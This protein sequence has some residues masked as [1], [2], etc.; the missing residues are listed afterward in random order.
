MYPTRNV[1]LR[2]LREPYDYPKSIGV[3]LGP[4]NLSKY[5][6]R[7]NNTRYVYDIVRQPLR[8][9]RSEQYGRT[10]L[11][12]QLVQKHDQSRDAIDKKFLYYTSNTNQNTC[13]FTSIVR[14]K[15]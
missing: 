11:Y 12:T 9:R 1:F 13:I 4:Y 8:C 5:N 7:S 3:A 10:G 14:Y 2:T 6:I 15:S